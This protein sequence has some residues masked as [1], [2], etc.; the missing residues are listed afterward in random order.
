MSTARKKAIETIEALFP[1]D[2]GYIGT[3]EIGEELLAQAKRE[4]Q[5]WRTE[6]TEILIRYA[7]LCV[8]RE[9]R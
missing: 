2:S 7:E 5:G 1:A 6:P 3:A 4:M 8:E 9:K